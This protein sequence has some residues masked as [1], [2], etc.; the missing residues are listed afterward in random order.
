MRQDWQGEQ[1]AKNSG[2]EQCREREGNEI[3][4]T[5][6]DKRGKG[7]QITRKVSVKGESKKRE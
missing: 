6:G 7:E 5:R 2:G 1:R 3:M 4:E